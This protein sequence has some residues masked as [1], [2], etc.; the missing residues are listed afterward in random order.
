MSPTQTVLPPPSRG[1]KCATRALEEKS[2]IH[3]LHTIVPANPTKLFCLIWKQILLELPTFC[4]IT[5]NFSSN[6]SQK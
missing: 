5:Y 4:L 2:V 6:S 3:Q 1:V